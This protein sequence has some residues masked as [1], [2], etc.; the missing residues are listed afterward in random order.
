MSISTRNVSLLR[1]C[2][3]SGTETKISNQAKHKYRVSADQKLPVGKHTI[4]FDFNYDGGG[5]GKGGD[6]VESVD[7][8]AVAVGRVERT[9]PFRL[10]GDETLDIGEDTGTPVS[11]DYKVPFKFTGT[12]KK[13]A[14]TL[15]ESRLSDANRKAIDEAKAKIGLSQ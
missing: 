8:K 12:L 7:G 2:S 3:A 13:L 10:A 14:I 1:N 11:D 4:T 15:G 5:I 9:L 6:V